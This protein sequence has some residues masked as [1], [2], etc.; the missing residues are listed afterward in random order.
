MPND[1][2]N[3]VQS[4][5][6]IEQAAATLLGMED[7]DNISIDEI[8]SAPGFVNPPTGRYKLKLDS[9]KT[10]VYTPKSGD[11]K[12]KKVRRLKHIYTILSVSELTD[13]S[14]QVPANGSKCSKNWNIDDKGLPYWKKHIEDLFGV[15]TIKGLTFGDL[16]AYVNEKAPAFECKI[17]MDKKLGADNTVLENWNMSI[18]SV[19]GAEGESAPAAGGGL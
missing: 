13:A 12:G 8:E 17:K 16:R 9:C 4:N 18:V 1:T 11:N 5:E 14:E 19:D 15:D 6:D 10:D 2:A 3:A 7:L